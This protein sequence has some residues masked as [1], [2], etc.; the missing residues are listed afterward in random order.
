MLLGRAG[1]GGEDA[2]G[3]TAGA[4]ASDDATDEQKSNREKKKEKWAEIL[5]AREAF[6][7]K[8]VHRLSRKKRRR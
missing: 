2:V 6:Q 8:Q 1:A 3:A 7:N 5:A 4:G